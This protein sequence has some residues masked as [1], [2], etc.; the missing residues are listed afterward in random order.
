MI[1][2]EVSEHTLLAGYR[3]GVRGTRLRTV[4]TVW[5]YV[6]LVENLPRLTRDSVTSKVQLSCAE[7]ER[8]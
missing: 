8:I 5:T 1:P 3:R 2:N 4:Q 6:G 7:S